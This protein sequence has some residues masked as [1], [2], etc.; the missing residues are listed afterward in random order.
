MNRNSSA[1]WA[2]VSGG[3]DVSVALCALLSQWLSILRPGA[4]VGD[5]AQDSQA[6]G[7]HEKA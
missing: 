1:A 5:P 3:S 7:V 2:P 4:C 6:P